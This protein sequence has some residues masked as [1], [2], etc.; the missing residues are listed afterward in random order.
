MYIVELIIK[1]K[2]KR[3]EIAFSRIKASNHA[4][5]YQSEKYKN[6]YACRR[7]STAIAMKLNGVHKEY[8]N[9]KMIRKDSFPSFMEI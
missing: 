1:G 5:L 9:G 2:D 7:K 6:V 8:K 3:N 4:T